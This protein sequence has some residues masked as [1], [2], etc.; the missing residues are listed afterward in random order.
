MR[1]LE[2]LPVD[3]LADVAHDVAE[4][5]EV[6]EERAVVGDRAHVVRVVVVPGVEL[7]VGRV[8]ISA[9]GLAS[10]GVPGSYSIT[11][12]VTSLGLRRRW[13]SSSSSV[14]GSVFTRIVALRNT[15]PS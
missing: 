6:P 12:P 11:E 15:E 8:R 10:P 1:V 13:R 9:I 7:V 3:R 5:G 14:N 4:A 2:V